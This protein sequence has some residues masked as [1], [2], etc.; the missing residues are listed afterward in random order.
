MSKYAKVFTEPS[1]THQSFRRECDVNYIIQ[2][3]RKIY[4]GDFLEV[5]KNHTGGSYGDFTAVVDYQSAIE[6]VRRAD[7]MF[8]A[9]PSNL[10]SKFDNDP[11]KFLDFCQNPANLEQMREMGLAKKAPVSDVKSDGAD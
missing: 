3:F 1:L 2:R 11:G 10:R 7:A 6:Q 8:D 5:Y 4:G 9:L